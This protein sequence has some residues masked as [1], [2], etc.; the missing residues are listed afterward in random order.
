[1]VARIWG[2]AVSP[3]EDDAYA[4]YMNQTGVREY[5]STDGNWAVYMLRRRLEEKT[6]FVLL[7]LWESLEGIKAF[8]GHDYE[9]AVFYP[10]DER[11]LIERD[12]RS[13]HFEVAA[14]SVPGG[15]TQGSDRPLTGTIMRRWRGWTNADDA[16]AYLRLLTE[17][18]LP[19][20]AARAIVGYNGAY[21]LRRPAEGE[22]QFMT[23]LLFDSLAAV[24]EFAGDDYEAAY[25]PE[26]ARRVLARFD[27]RS[28]HYDVLENTA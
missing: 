3:A 23:L 12:V 15:S 24:R 1:M 28:V 13:T 16:A 11:F 25:V 5:R 2:G 10:E 18:V 26:D 8:A 14:V 27:E 22:L 20:I 17:D 9:R 4:D 21:V 6:D 7:T 19:G